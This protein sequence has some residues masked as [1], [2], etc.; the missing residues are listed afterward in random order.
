MTCFVGQ[1]PVEDLG[2]EAFEFTMEEE[3]EG[4][5]GG[6]GE[7]KVEGTKGQERK[8]SL[9]GEEA[10]KRDLEVQVAI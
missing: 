7:D 10:K 8:T 1:D 3:G 4:V 9:G 2:R 5:D 6:E